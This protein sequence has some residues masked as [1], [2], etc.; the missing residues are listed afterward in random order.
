MKTKFIK[1]IENFYAVFLETHT[2]TD[3]ALKHYE[4]VLIE[5][6][7]QM[8]DA[9]VQ[10]E[11]VMALARGAIIREH[12][13]TGP[14]AILKGSILPTETERCICNWPYATA[15]QT[16]KFTNGFSIA[17]PNSPMSEREIAEEKIYEL[18]GVYTGPNSFNTKDMRTLSMLIAKRN[19]L[20]IVE[21]MGGLNEV[22]PAS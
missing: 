18:I 2:F 9:I 8:F 10:R 1:A 22:Q 21:V 3:D 20:E 5:F 15:P 6:N 17:Q 7:K 12:D 14:I 11:F 13:S 4:S 16:M 19:E